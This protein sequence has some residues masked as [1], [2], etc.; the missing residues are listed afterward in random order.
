M[1]ALAIVGGGAP[2]AG[3]ALGERALIA[4]LDP[5][6]GMPDPVGGDL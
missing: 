3:G 4:R 2:G 1:K 5:V 6:R